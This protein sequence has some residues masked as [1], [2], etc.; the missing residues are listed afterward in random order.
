MGMHGGGWF[1]YI[2]HDKE[3]DQPEISRELLLRVW[4][5][6]QP[7]WLSVLGLLITILLITGLSLISPLLY[8]NLIDYAIPNGDIARL[9]L[10]ALGMIGIPLLNGVIGVWQRRLNS[11][12]G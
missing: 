11:Q 12:I 5:F 1:A 10:L 7:Y 4:D 6:A 9:N 2:R 3:A 8:R